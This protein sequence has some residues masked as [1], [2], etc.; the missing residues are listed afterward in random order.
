M[1]LNIAFCISLSASSLLASRVKVTYFS[2]NGQEAAQP[3]PVGFTG[4]PKSRFA[5]F[6][7]DEQIYL[8]KDR[9]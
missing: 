2:N 3:F 8:K 7:S 4:V 9:L 6:L 1:A 5:I